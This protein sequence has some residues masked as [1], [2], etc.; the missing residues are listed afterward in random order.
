MIDLLALEG[1]V[2]DNV[3]GCPGV[4]EKTAAKL[5]TQFGSVENMLENTDRIKGALRAK[6]EGAAEQIRFS[7]FLVTIKTDVPLDRLSRG[8]T[9]IVIA[10]RLSTIRNADTIAVIEHGRIAE[11]GS[12]RELLEKNGI[13]TALYEAQKGTEDER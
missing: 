7:K 1:D 9:S 6:V 2:S 8:R 11:R 3:P 13:Y 12:H 4:G 5:I 10:H